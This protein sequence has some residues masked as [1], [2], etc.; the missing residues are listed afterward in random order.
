MKTK[1]MSNKRR[2]GRVTR[3]SGN[4]FA[5]LGFDPAEAAELQVKAELT[6]QIYN[7]VKALR[8]T[9]VQAAARLGCEST[10]RLE[11][12]ARAVHW[13]LDGPPDRTPQC[14]SGRC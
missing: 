12:D 13:L 6:R 10:G 7:R 2:D 9:Q 5:D 3:G 4:V 14:A 8:L 1:R 11:A